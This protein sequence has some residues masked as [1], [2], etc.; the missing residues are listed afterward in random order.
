VQVDELDAPS[1]AEAV[2]GE[3][4]WQAVTDVAPD[5]TEKVPAGQ[6]SQ[7][8][9]LYEVE[10]FPTGHNLHA[11]DWYLPGTQAGVGAGVVG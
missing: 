5:N 11:G 6:T 4:Y 8:G 1:L 9:E 2:P 3:Q 10:Y 7:S